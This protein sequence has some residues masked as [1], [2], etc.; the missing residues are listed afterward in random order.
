MTDVSGRNRTQGR[1]AP[2]NHSVSGVTLDPAAKSSPASVLSAAAGSGRTPG[3]IPWPEPPI[4]NGYVE[5]NVSDENAW[6]VLERHGFEGDLVDN[7][8]QVYAGISLAADK[9]ADFHGVKADG[10]TEIIAMG[11]QDYEQAVDPYEHENLNYREGFSNPMPPYLAAQNE[12]KAK[13]LSLAAD[14]LDEAG[15]SV[16]LEDLRRHEFRLRNADGNDL[17]LR[18]RDFQPLELRE[19]RNWHNADDSHIAEFLGDGYT[20][21]AG[22]LLKECA[23]LVAR[24]Q[25]RQGYGL[26]S[27]D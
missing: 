1:F 16:E 26:P 18:V 19:T 24:D 3:S 5:V 14:V 4:N 6:S 15:V 7:F 20:E 11:L 22:K 12:V 21:G 10:S 23:N 2:E 17:Q 25:V 8:Q 27:D 9:S 13:R